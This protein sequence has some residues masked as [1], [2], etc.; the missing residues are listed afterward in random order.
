MNDKE[1]DVGVDG[2]DGDGGV[3]DDDDLFVSPFSVRLTLANL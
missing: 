2:D 3:D 1:E